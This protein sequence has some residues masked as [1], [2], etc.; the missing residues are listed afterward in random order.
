MN[1]QT[2]PTLTNGKTDLIERSMHKNMAA[3]Y[4]GYQLITPTMKYDLVEVSTANGP[5]R[6]EL[7]QAQ[8]LSAKGFERN[9][10][11]WTGPDA[12]EPW[13]SHVTF[14]TAAEYIRKTIHERLVSERTAR[15]ESARI[16]QER[17]AEAYRRT[18]AHR[19][20]IDALLASARWKKTTISVDWREGGELVRKDLDVKAFGLVGLRKNGAVWEITHIPTGFLMGSFDTQHEA[21]IACVRFSQHDLNRD[22]KAL[23]SDKAL[24]DLARAMRRTS[25]AYAEIL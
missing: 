11:N 25:D 14:N 22:A 18:T 21:K 4:D 9:I 20:A 17:Q 19:A 15:E 2:T 23:G 16:E 10:L 5:Y 7:R 12:S 13:D 3:F 6:W 8:E 1:T 24:G